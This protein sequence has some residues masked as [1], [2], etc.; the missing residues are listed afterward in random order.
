[1]PPRPASRRR[2]PNWQM[3]DKITAIARDEA[4]DVARIAMPGVDLGP[5]LMTMIG[6]R[7]PWMMMIAMGED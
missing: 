4:A 2:A 7:I 3:P 6:R 5:W 1:M